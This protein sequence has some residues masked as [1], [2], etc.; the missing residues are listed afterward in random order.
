[1]N[2]VRSLLLLEGAELF[3]YVFD[4]NLF[5]DLGFCSSVTRPLKRG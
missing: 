3:G 2:E 1:M 4:A 5:P